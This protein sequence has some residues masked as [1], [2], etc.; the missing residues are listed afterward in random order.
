MQEVVSDDEIL[1]VLKWVIDNG[2]QSD[3]RQRP[4]A[5]AINNKLASF[6]RELIESP[7]SS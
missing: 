6:I 2:L 3:P 5:P 4:S 7:A 1:L